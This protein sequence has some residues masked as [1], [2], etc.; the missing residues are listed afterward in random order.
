MSNGRDV[1]EGESYHSRSQLDEAVATV[2]PDADTRSVVPAES[3][4]NAVYFVTATT[5]G[6]R[7]EMVLKVGTRFGGPAFRA[8]P[9]LLEAVADRTAIPVP[10]VLGTGDDALAEPY[11]LAERVSG[12]NC[13]CAPERVAPEAFERVCFEAGRNLG[14]LHAAFSADGFGLL[15]VEA[16][17]D[18]LSFSRAFDDWPG[19]FEAWATQ[20]VERLEDTRFA[21][22]VPALKA[23]VADFAV[24]LAD[25]GSYDPAITHG[26]YRL[27]NVLLDADALSDGATLSDDANATNAVVDWATP[28]AAPPEF[29]LAQTEAILVDWPEFDADRQ[30]HLRERL[31]EGYRR[32]NSLERGD[33]FAARRRRYR[34]AASVRLAVNLDDEMAGRTEEAADARAREHRATFRGYG[35][36]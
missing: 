20:N 6:D 29:E 25:L 36:E 26:D 34:L 30:R 21:D 14:E 16:G 12:E 5:D 32:S 17:D 19:L 1:S 28:V 9:Y 15:G 27:G 18:R 2:L 3:G 7:R 11:F 31:Y 33:D 35:V 10:T 22:L 24:D 13:E 4:K 23:R 8:E